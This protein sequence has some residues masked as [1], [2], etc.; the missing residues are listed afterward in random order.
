MITLKAAQLVTGTTA[1]VCV[2]WGFGTGW[3]ILG[4]FALL[5]HLVLDGLIWKLREDPTRR[6]Q[7]ASSA[8]DPFYD[9]CG[10]HWY[11]TEPPLED[12]LP[13]RAP[14]WGSPSE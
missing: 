10:F 1:I 6:R 9:S 7:T 3:F 8:R 11:A 14:V 13:Y 12:E 2:A 4:M 5:V